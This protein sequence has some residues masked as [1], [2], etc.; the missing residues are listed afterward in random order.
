MGLSRSTFY[1]PQARLSDDEIVAKIRAITDEFECYGYRRVAAELRHRG[2]VINAK[3]VRRLMREHNLNARKRRRFTRT[4]DSDHD[5]PIFPFVARD[6]EVHGP[7]Q[8]W[9]ADLTYV[10]IATGFVYLAVILDAWSRRVVGYSIGR[11]LDAR[12]AVAALE[13]A[14]ALRRPLPGCVVH[15]DRG[16]QYASEKHRALLTAHGLFGSMSRRGNPY[17]NP[18][19]ESFMKTLKVE[20]VYLAEYDTYEDVAADLPRFIDEVYNTR[21][22]HSALG[23]LSPIQFEDRNARAP[24]KTAA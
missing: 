20:A 2:L 16:S 10:A 22:L 5:G 3:K 17:D 9:V 24:V 11:S 14:V 18:K 23:Y 4:T 13:R 19:A 1:A 15:T 7:D 8:L 21:R 6:F 12:H